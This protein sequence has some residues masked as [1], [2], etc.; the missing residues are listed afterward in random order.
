MCSTEKHIP[1]FIDNKK[2]IGN[3]NLTTPSPISQKIFQTRDRQLYA[4]NT[5]VLG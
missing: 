2:H 5:L 1:H 3:K 4:E